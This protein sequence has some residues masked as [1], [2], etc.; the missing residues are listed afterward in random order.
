MKVVF[1]LVAGDWGGAVVHFWSGCAPFVRCI[2]L[3]IV[4]VYY[5][6]FW[7]YGG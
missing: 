6:L 7:S 2:C 1:V 3:L 4:T 5:V